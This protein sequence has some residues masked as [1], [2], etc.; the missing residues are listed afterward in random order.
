[1]A[2]IG[3]AEILDQTIAVLR[4]AFEGPAAQWSYF[5]DNDPD[6]GLLGSLRDVSARE[7]SRT[8]GQGSIAS[9]VNHMCFAVEA[10]R[11]WIVGDRSPKDWAESWNITAVE[12]AQWREMIQDLEDGYRAL[13]ETIR[14]GALSSQEAMGAAVA[15]IAHAAYHL[16]AIEQK[17]LFR[18]RKKK[19]R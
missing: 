4:E 12:D 3:H 7:A 10:S 17:L 2:D 16:G 8:V 5:T 1:M 15:A 13:S 6:A 9:H 19:R 18:G 14:D 11:A